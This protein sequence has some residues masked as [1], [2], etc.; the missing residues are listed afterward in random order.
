MAP[1]SPGCA[2]PA[3]RSMRACC[4][5]EADEL[6]AGFRSRVRRGRPLVTL[7]LASTLDGRI[8]TRVRREPLDHR[9]GRAPRGPRAAR[10]ARRGD[11]R[12]RHGAGRR[13]GADLPA[14]RLSA[15]TPVVRVV[16]DSHLRTP[17]TATLVATAARGAD[18]DADPR[19]HRSR[20]PSRLRR[21]RCHADRGRRA[22]RPA[23]IRRR[24]WPRWARRGSPGC[25]WR[26]AHSLPPRCCA[27]TWWTA[28]P[29]SMRPP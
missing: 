27:P 22:P 8:A 12:R 28:S 5:D 4:S 20:A 17:L 18:L 10:P 14:A 11:G 13:S 25:W 23:S 24:R 6:V 29:G 2:R 1:A 21:S 9:R 3:S 26:A 19:R 15:P 16:A 7:K